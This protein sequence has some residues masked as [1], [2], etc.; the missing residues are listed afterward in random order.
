M[1]I[2]EHDDP[3]IGEASWDLKDRFITGEATS[4]LYFFVVESHVNRGQTQTGS[5]VIHR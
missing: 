4:G 3:A 1:G 5:F 2:I